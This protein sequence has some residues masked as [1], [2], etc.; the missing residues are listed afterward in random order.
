LVSP[1]ATSK[2]G[3]LLPLLVKA[4]V[5]SISPVVWVNPLLRLEPS[6]P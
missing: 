6:V 2:S 1:V 4:T 5:T 3:L